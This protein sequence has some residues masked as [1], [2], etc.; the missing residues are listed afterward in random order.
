[1]SACHNACTVKLKGKNQRARANSHIVINYGTKKKQKQESEKIPSLESHRRPSLHCK[2]KM[3]RA[4]FCNSWSDGSTATQPCD[5][6]YSLS[7]W[8]HFGGF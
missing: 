8:S 5:I 4:R 7:D 2:R 3:L 1:M 6:F